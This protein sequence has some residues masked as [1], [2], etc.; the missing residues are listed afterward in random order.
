ML[1]LQE[2]HENIIKECIA[3]NFE[4]IRE[5]K[6][7]PKRKQN[8]INNLLIKL[9]KKL[10]YLIKYALKIHSKLEALQRV[11]YDGLI[12]LIVHNK[13]QNGENFLK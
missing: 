11:F 9:N 12:D 3:H 1:I 13:I 10:T 5:L 4:E 8:I 7:E 2:K 6:V